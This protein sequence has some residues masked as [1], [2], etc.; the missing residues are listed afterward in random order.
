MLHRLF[1]RLATEL[2]L[3]H[4][5]SAFTI[6]SVAAIIVVSVLYPAASRLAGSF[7]FALTVVWRQVRYN[8]PK[9]EAHNDEAPKAP[10]NLATL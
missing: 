8:E 9:S 6:S 7:C 2:Q 1:F 10:Q 5:V 4:Q 3:L